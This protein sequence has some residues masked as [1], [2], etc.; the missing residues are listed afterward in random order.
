VAVP[1]LASFQRRLAGADWFHFDAPRHRI[2]LT[3]AGLH[4]LLARSGFEIVEER[5]MVWQH[6]VPGMWFAL[7]TRLGMSAGFPF[8]LAKR[9]IDP[10]PADLVL[11]AVGTLLLPVALLLEGAAAAFRRG[12]TVAVLSR[13][14]T[15]PEAPARNAPR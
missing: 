3:R 9:N 1:N 7:L 15:A 8:H 4:R 10:A 11:L 13:A 5:H 6:N 14:S 2:H 12:G